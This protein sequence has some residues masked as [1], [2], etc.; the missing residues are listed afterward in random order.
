MFSSSP[1]FLARLDNGRAVHE[2]SLVEVAV[3]LCAVDRLLG[4]EDNKKRAG[5]PADGDYV[6]PKVRT[7]CRCCFLV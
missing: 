7:V 5:E 3:S 2:S 6:D 1:Q 4:S